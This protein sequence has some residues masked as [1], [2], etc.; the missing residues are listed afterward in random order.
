MVLAKWLETVCLQMVMKN[1][2]DEHAKTFDCIVCVLLHVCTRCLCDGWCALLEDESCD[3]HQSRGNEKG[4][5][6]CKQ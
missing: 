6:C 5:V 3:F 2:H 4:T 1:P